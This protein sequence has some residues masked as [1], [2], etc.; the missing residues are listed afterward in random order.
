M[1]P[2][3]G[4]SASGLVRKLQGTEAKALEPN[5]A[6]VSWCL[7]LW[8]SSKE[9]GQKSQT[10]PCLYELISGLVRKPD[11][12]KNSIQGSQVALCPSNVNKKV[13]LT[14][15]FSSFSVTILMET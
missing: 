10:Q 11:V 13:R 14:L 8:E 1:G 3:L 15:C 4:E 2:C 6:C 5:C 9:L 12:Q 7:A